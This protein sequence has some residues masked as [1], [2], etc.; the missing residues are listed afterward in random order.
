MPADGLDSFQQNSRKL[1]KKMENEDKKK[2]KR[3]NE[4]E[5][6]ELKKGR[7]AAKLKQGKN[8]GKLDSRMAKTR[9]GGE[10]GLGR[11]NLG[12]F[13]FFAAAKFRNSQLI[14]E[15]DVMVHYGAK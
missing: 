7:R 5:E 12:F 11:Y 13:F 9:S 14:I 15:Y 10:I 3:E 1:K 6:V 4:K 2:E 8:R